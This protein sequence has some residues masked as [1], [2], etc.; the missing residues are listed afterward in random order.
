MERRWIELSLKIL[1]PVCGL[2]SLSGCSSN[3]ADQDLSPEYV[4][5]SITSLTG[6][7]IDGTWDERDSEGRKILGD[8]ALPSART[9]ADAV[10]FCGPLFVTI[11]RS[12][13]HT[14]FV[15]FPSGSGEGKSDLEVVRCI[16]N[17]VG[18]AFSAGIGPALK[19]GET[20]DLDYTPFVS[21][22]SKTP[23]PRP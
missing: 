17:N 2:I 20:S 22:Q 12:W 7:T 8:L 13:T 18:F 21:L 4:V 3:K 19:P 9:M 10:Y 5:L 23:P 16:R 14:E 6:G 1:A 15:S 11:D